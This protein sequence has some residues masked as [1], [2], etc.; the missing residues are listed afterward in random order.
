MTIYAMLL[1]S[2][3]RGEGQIKNLTKSLNGMEWI[4]FFLIWKAKARHKGKDAPILHPPPP[5][6]WL[7]VI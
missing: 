5:P 4:L 1:Q 3:G 7:G 2:K 6:Q